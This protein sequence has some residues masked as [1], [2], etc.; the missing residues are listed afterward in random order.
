MTRRR[1]SRKSSSFQIKPVLYIACAA[2]IIIGWFSFGETKAS[3]PAE[4]NAKIAGSEAA[5][6]NLCKVIVPNGT[7]EEIVEYP[8]FTVSFNRQHHQ[9]N[10][11]A[12][13][14]TRGETQGTLP[15][16]NNFAQD[17]KV[18][19]CPT[20]DDY[21]NSGYDRGHMAPAAD[22]KWNEDAMNACFYLTNM[23]PQA[24]ALNSGS[25]K[26][27]EDK[28]RDWAVRDSAIIIVCGPVLTDRITKTIG[29]TKV[30]VPSRYF[31]VILAPYANP[32]RAIGF[33]MNNGKVAGGMQQAAVSVDEVERITGFDFFAELPDDIENEVEAQ[34]NF[35]LWSR[36]K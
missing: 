5:A 10:W 27:L 23:S 7:V 28:C 11:V 31:K 35:T 25:W 36:L 22:M 20:L 15:R 6:S 32:P 1:K 30:S 21:R 8:G 26:K 18:D 9:P 33:I 29:D 16:S 13:E 12:W 17:P 24:S 34:C 4:S 3:E 19:G 2:A 14:L